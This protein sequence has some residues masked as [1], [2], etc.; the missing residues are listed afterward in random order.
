MRLFGNSGNVGTAAYLNVFGSIYRVLKAL[1]KEGYTID[2]PKDENELIEA[3]L[4][5]KEAK[6]QSP[7]LNIAY[8]MPVSEYEVTF[9]FY[10]Q[11]DTHT[12][13]PRWSFFFF[14]FP[15]EL[16]FWLAAL[17][18]IGETGTDAIC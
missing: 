17:R 13:T 8:K 9:F 16:T 1:R 11:A 6:I 14:S 18:L 5:D 12:H 7:E 3:V 15:P 2:L 4:K 10:K